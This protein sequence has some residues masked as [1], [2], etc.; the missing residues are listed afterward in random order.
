M[1]EI[2]VK[3]SF[4]LDGALVVGTHYFASPVVSGQYLLI[5]V[6]YVG[7]SIWEISEM[8]VGVCDA[9]TQRSPEMWTLQ[10]VLSQTHAAGYCELARAPGW[11]Y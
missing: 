3:W 11:H 2:E 5:H 4:L 1:K 9:K 10:G 7:T 8:S 6:I